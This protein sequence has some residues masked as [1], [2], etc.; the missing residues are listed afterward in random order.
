MTDVNDFPMPLKMSAERAARIIR[1]GLN[2]DKARIAFPL[3]LYWLVRLMAALPPDA[4]EPLLRR[5][6]EKS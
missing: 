1:R 6:P 5:L 2:A 3:R 4:L